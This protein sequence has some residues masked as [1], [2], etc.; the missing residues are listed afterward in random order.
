MVVCSSEGLAGRPLTIG[1]S[2]RGARLRR[3]KEGIDDWDK[4][5]SFDAGEAPRR[6]TSSLDG[7]MRSVCVFL[8]ALVL[9][10]CGMSPENSLRRA[11]PQNKNT[12]I[13][14]LH[15]QL[16][17]PQLVRIAPSF[18]RLDSDWS[19]PRENVGIS[20]DRWD[21]YRRLFRQANIVDGIQFDHGYLFYF[22]A[23]EGL[24][25]GGTSRGYA[26]TK[27]LPKVVVDH[28]SD[29]P[30]QEGVC[31]VKMEPDWYI[32]QWVT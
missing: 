24:A 26:Y 3:A 13:E 14:L 27:V 16:E 20:P 29:C 19:W 8:S 4:V 10:G 11:Y 17:D 25:I 30:S 21:T 2:D 9:T 32:F 23:S 5:P 18:T 7:T 31:F 12:L 28:L 15:M 1:S 22:A 6:S